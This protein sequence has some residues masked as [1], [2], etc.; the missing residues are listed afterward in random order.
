MVLS[1]RYLTATDDMNHLELIQSVSLGHRFVL[2]SLEALKPGG[3]AVHYITITLSS[4]SRHFELSGSG[5]ITVWTKTDVELLMRD[6]RLLGYH[7]FPSTW[8]AGTGFRDWFPDTWHATHMSYHD[9]GHLKLAH[10][11]HVISTFALVV[12]RPL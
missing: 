8:A 3:V 5:G 12:Q 7:V 10:Y 1:Y 4:L 2:N 9:H 11:S 6:A